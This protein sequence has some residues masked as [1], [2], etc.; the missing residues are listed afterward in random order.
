MHSK[1]GAAARAPR[2]GRTTGWQSIRHSCHEDSRAE[3]C[4]QL[5]Q[6]FSG[7]RPVAFEVNGHGSPPRPP[8]TTEYGSVPR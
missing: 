2:D 7:T 6:D 1:A 8:M 4:V 3:G 5:Q